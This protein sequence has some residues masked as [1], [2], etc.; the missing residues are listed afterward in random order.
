VT[1]EIREIYV[2]A[3]VRGPYGETEISALV[4]TGATITLLMPD[5][6]EKVGLEDPKPADICG[7]YTCKPTRSGY[8]YVT[9][10]GSGCPEDRA[11]AFEYPDM[12]IIGM[13][14]MSDKGVKIDTRTGAVSCGKKYRY[15]NI[16]KELRDFLGV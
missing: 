6:I 14:P 9:I 3:K 2:K 1:G 5:V 8:V 15:R 11:L 7:I 10:P 4:D 16:R 13:D 12:N